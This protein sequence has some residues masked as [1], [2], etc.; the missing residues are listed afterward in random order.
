MSKSYKKAQ[1]CAFLLSKRHF[2]ASA[3]DSLRICSAHL[4]F[5][6]FVAMMEDPSGTAVGEPSS[7]VYTYF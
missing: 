5:V 7:I 3:S 6:T 1:Y 4:N 2:S